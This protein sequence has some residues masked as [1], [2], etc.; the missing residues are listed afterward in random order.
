MGFLPL[1]SCH[2]HHAH[3]NTLCWG[4][5]ALRPLA[6][7]CRNKALLIVETDTLLYSNLRSGVYRQL[8]ASIEDI[9][10]QDQIGK[11][12][13]LWQYI[14]G[15]PWDVGACLGVC[16]EN[17][18]LG[19]PTSQDGDDGKRWLYVFLVGHCTCHSSETALHKYNILK[20]PVGLAGAWGQHFFIALWAASMRCSSSLDHVLM[21]STV[22]CSTAMY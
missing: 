20:G 13:R 18:V 3:N 12:K 17:T 4:L 11:L 6:S 15:F 5:T 7:L 14:I 22:E 10:K 9:R 8:T 1:L 16:E 19:L 21:S 2:P